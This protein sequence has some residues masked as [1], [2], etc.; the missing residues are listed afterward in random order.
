M[1]PGE[2]QHPDHNVNVFGS[3][4]DWANAA[5]DLGLYVDP[6]RNGPGYL[7]HTRADEEAGEFE[8]NDSDSRGSLAMDGS[9]E[10]YQNWKDALDLRP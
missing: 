2:R 10:T 6:E 7:A 9:A 4:Y 5:R 8:G 3:Y 1:T